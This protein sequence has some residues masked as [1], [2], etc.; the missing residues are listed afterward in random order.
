LELR[1]IAHEQR[2]CVDACLTRCQKVIQTLKTVGLAGGE[3]H[4]LDQ[5]VS[6]SVIAMEQLAALKEYRTPAALRAFVRIYLL[7]RGAPPFYELS[8]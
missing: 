5:Y 1:E 8:F 3:A 6:K 2:L 7:V 4:R